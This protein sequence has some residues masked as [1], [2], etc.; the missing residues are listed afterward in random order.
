MLTDEQLLMIEALRQREIPAG[1]GIFDNICGVLQCASEEIHSFYLLT[2]GM[3]NGTFH[4]S[5]REE[6]YVYRHP[7]AGTE[8]YINRRAEAEAELVASRLGLDKTFLHMDP[9]E[10]WKISRF[11]QNCRTL[12]YHDFETVGKSLQAIR[13]LHE[14]RLP[15][16]WTFDLSGGI[17]RFLRLI[18]PDWLSSVQGFPALSAAV[19]RVRALA[20][21][22]HPHPCLCHCDFYNNNLLTDGKDLFLVDWE[23][24]GSCDPALDIGTFIG[25]SDYTYDEALEVLALYYGRAPRPDELRHMLAAVAITSYYWFLW[26]TYQASRDFDVGNYMDIWRGFAEEYSDRAAALY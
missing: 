6:E 10:G 7:G 24:A 5:C 3:T 9:G 15:S 11:I 21:G 25:A 20:D 8:N 4:F 12:D 2:T 18:G 17:D 22:D 23:F 19:S 16:A 26:G 14:A 13:R 1:P